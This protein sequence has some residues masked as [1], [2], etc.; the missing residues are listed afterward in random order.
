MA[1]T[2]EDR[3][4][5]FVGGEYVS[6]SGGD[7]LETL[8]PATERPIASVADGTA[9][10][11]DRAVA[12]ASAALEGWRTTAPAERGRLLGAVAEAIR[13]HRTELAEL[14]SRDQ[15]KPLSQAEGDVDGAARYF[16][17]YAGAADKLEGTSVP[18]DHDHLDFTIREPYGVSGQITPWNFPVG[19]AARGIAPALAAGNTTVLKPAPTTPLTTLR[20]AELCRA[21][22][23]PDGV[24]NVV[25]GGGE[26]GAALAE[27]PDVD[28][29]TFTGS[30]RTGRAVMEAAAE[31]I[32][33]VT[34]ELGGKNPAVV[35]PDADL[36]AA[37][38]AVAT[39]IFRNA[40]QVCSAADRAI[41]HESVHDE[42]VDRIVAAA[43]GLTVGP[44]LDDPDV[45]PLNHAAHRETVREYV[46]TGEREGATLATGGGV[47]DRDGYFVEPTVFTGVE[48]ETTIAREEIFGPVLSVL[49]VADAAEAVRIANDVEYG[50]TAGVFARDVGRA[51]SVARDL[52]A[53][54]VYVNEWFGGG[55]ETPFG[56]R[57]HS[58]IGREKGLEGLDSYLQTKNVSIDLGGGY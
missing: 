53:G 18:L 3:Y 35:L 15:G 11:V 5:Q 45:G 58:G 32:T 12:A 36:D 9:A 20:L 33:P 31:T 57:K 51:L 2:H 8:D 54:S 30:V 48:P 23:L 7:R 49:S 16:E 44:G 14:E 6:S 46:A 19:L 40:G 21:A 43:E 26:P 13:D 50:L 37:A 56:G 17:Y 1:T 22:G 25:T 38:E 4:D 47:P 42:F 39:G 34:L 41:V 24:V 27:H 55:V 52:E 28:V 10:D 29:L